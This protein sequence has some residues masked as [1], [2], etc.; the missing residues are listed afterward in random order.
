MKY[1]PRSFEYEKKAARI[2]KEVVHIT[3]AT[4]SPEGKPWN[5]PVHSAFDSDLN[6]YWASAKDSTHS[7]NI[8]F[9]PDVFLAIYDSTALGGTG[10]AVYFEARAEEL[11]KREE[12]LIAKKFAQKRIKHTEES[13]VDDFIG[14]SIRRVYQAVIT[15]GW[16]NDVEVLP[17][18][19]LRQYR[20]EVDLRR[21]RG[22]L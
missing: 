6:F 19:Q 5:T 10:S 15:R 7:R 12:I 18:R 9:Q 4:V 21:L 22:L 16:T 20:V 11:H 14:D 3:I 8:R 1:E 17:D 13:D 2:I